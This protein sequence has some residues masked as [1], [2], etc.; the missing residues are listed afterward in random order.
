MLLRRLTRKEIKIG[1]RKGQR[2]GTEIYKGE[3]RGRCRGK[4]IRLEDEWASNHY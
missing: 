3:N 4:K 2:L 1:H